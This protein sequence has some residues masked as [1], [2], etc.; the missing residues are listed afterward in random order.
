M[1]TVKNEIENEVVLGTML[2]N[3]YFW[4]LAEI[5]TG[6]AVLV[7]ETKNQKL[8]IS[9][10]YNHIWSRNVAVEMVQEKRKLIILTRKLIRKTVETVND[11][12]KKK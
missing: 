3:K 12:N 4:G 11:E 1:S 5:R 8:R 6:F 7:K 9:Y 2:K 10:Y